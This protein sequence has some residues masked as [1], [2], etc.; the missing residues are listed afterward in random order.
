MNKNGTILEAS[1]EKAT[2][3]ARVNK[4]VVEKYK[5][6]DIPIS[7][8]IETSLINFMKLSDQE[9]IKFINE[10]I[11]EKVNTSDLMIPKKKWDSL[12]KDYLIKLKIPNSVM[13]SLFMGTAIGAITLIGGLLTTLDSDTFKDD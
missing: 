1:N 3:S 13:T 5:S 12:L 11:P 9:K 2:V 6:A 10:N 4:Y 8:V 7:L